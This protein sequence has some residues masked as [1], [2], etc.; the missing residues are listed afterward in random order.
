MKLIP[1]TQGQFAIVDD[2]D[3]EELSKYKWCAL[4]THYGDYMAV[5][6]APSPKRTL[7]YMHRQ[8]LGLKRGDKRQCDHIHHNRLDNRKSELR[9]CTA[10]QNRQNGQSHRGSTSEYK[11]VFWHKASKKWEVQIKVNG[12]HIY[13]GLFDSEIAAARAYDRVA[14]KYFGDFAY[15]N[16]PRSNYEA[17]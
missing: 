11:G 1:L 10:R 16:F 14:I 13:L 5:R 4:K 2:K 12:K 8:I 7:I 3:Y 9:V 15:L 17:A 6:H